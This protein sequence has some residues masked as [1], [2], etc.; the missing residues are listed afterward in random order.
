V[1]ADSV[2]MLT[3]ISLELPD[4]FARSTIHPQRGTVLVAQVAEAGAVR[5]SRAAALRFAVR[6]GALGTGTGS[7]TVTFLPAALYERVRYGAAAIPTRAVA[8]REVAT[9]RGLV[10]GVTTGRIRAAAVRAD[11]SDPILADHTGDHLS[12]MAMV[13]SI[14]DA[15]RAAGEERVLAALHIAFMSYAEFSPSPTL[16]FTVDDDGTIEGAVH[17]SGLQRAVF[18]GRTV[19]ETTH[20]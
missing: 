16:L 9:A 7:A 10:D 8:T 6:S 3:S 1:P 12:A 13:C 4:T 14:E 11:L 20:H 17:Q 15:V 18:S 5:R 19:R 2:F